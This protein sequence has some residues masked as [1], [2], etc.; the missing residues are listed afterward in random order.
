MDRT[1]PTS[2]F[3]KCISG[4]S[5]VSGNSNAPKFQRKH[6]R[7]VLTARDRPPQWHH[8][9][10]NGSTNSLLGNAW[11]ICIYLGGCIEAEHTLYTSSAYLHTQSKVKFKSLDVDEGNKVLM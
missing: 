9:R 7:I 11:Q 4:V 5:K 6:R 1:T 2:I 3:H 8:W 10:G